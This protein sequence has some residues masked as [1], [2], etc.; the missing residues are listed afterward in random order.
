MILLDS[1][2]KVSEHDEQVELQ[3]SRL[4]DVEYLYMYSYKKL[5]LMF[6]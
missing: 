2:N 6:D 5:N 1:E 4:E 3:E